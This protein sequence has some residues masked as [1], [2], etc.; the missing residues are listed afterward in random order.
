[1]VKSCPIARLFAINSFF[2]MPFFSDV[3]ILSNMQYPQDHFDLFLVTMVICESE[4]VLSKFFTLNRRQL[5]TKDRKSGCV[6][7]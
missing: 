6:I 7:Q 2:L 5:N 1:M 3:L 4:K